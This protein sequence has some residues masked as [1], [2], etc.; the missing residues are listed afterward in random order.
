MAILIAVS[1]AFS[2]NERELSTWRRAKAATLGNVDDRTRCLCA[3]VA[4][5]AVLQSV[6]LREKD[7]TIGYGEHGKPFLK[8]Y[9]HL[10]FNLSHSGKWAV[11]A[12]SD[13]PIGVDVEQLRQVDALRLAARWL[14]AKQAKLLKTS[15][16]TEQIP[17]FFE[18]WTR[19][20]SLLKAQGVGLS[21]VCAAEETGYR[22]RE[23]PLDGY[24]LTV[25]TQGDLPERLTIIE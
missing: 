14:P 18:F 19:R 21:G 11:C 22:F 2:V 25:C 23:Y 1:T 4:L 7:V 12:L 6:N 24:A 15:P 8:D 3:G 10:H 16:P 13:T 5:D 17:R 20:E 9:P